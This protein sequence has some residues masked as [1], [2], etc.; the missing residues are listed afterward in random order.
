MKKIIIL[1]CTA[2]LTTFINAGNDTIPTNMNVINEEVVLSESTTDNI[3]LG[4]D[5]SKLDP[6]SSIIYNGSSYD[7]IFSWKNRKKKRLSSH[8]T[9][10]GMG[11]MNYDDNGI[12]NGKLKMSSSH[13]FSLNLFNYSM[14]IKNSNWLFVSG[15]GFEWFRYHFDGNAGLVKRD[16]ITVFEPAP[17]GVDYKS[18]MLLAYYI[19]VP[20]LMEYQIPMGRSNFHISGGVVGFLKYYSKSQIEYKVEGKNQK[21]VLGRDLN[22]RPYDLKLRL[23]AGIGD[24]SLFGYYSPFSLFNNNEGPDLKTYS[25][26]MMLCF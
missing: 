24:I 4:L 26:G 6:E 19:T 12:P 21:E 3:T 17:D 14:H 7:F 25:I 22:I 20:L 23:Q 18:N 1:F 13:S 9:G 16:G 11:F 2:L 5:S 10:F 15:I 8:W